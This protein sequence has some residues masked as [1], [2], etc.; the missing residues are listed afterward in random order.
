MKKS[1]ESKSAFSKTWCCLFGNV[2]ITLRG[3]AA[4]SNVS[5]DSEVMTLNMLAHL[6]FTRLVAKREIRSREVISKRNSGM[7]GL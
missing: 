4:V 6:C 1:V 2:S 5:C 3:Y 7:K